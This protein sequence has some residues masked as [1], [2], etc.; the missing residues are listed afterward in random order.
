[1]S[2]QW[3]SQGRVEAIIRARHARSPEEIATA[4]SEEDQAPARRFGSA[5]TALLWAIEYS[6]RAL[7]FSKPN[8]LHNGMRQIPA[9][10]TRDELV[11]LAH[12]ITSTCHQLQRKAPANLLCVIC[13]DDDGGRWNDVL[14]VL[15]DEV[16]ARVETSANR[17]QLRTLATV[18]V[19]RTRNAM[20][21]H[22]QIPRSAYAEA[23]GVKRPSVYEGKWREP[24]EEIEETIREWRRQGLQ[25]LKEALMDKGIIQ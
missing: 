6:T 16:K 10:P 3:R 17:A 14:G 2:K 4:L 20:H 22:D 11:D 23:V 9:G 13:G 25:D 15:A 7:G 1:M 24:I 8:M 21:H 19:Q 18:A 12:T 5:Q